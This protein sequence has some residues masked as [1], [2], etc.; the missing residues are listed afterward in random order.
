MRVLFWFVGSLLCSFRLFVSSLLRT[1]TF[2]YRCLFSCA[3]SPQY[4]HVRALQARTLMETVA[5]IRCE[6][7]TH[8]PVFIGG[9]FNALPG[10]IVQTVMCSPTFV[11]RQHVRE[12]PLVSLHLPPPLSLYSAVAVPLMEPLPAPAAVLAAAAATDNTRADARA[13]QAVLQATRE[14][15]VL[16]YVHPSDHAAAAAVHADEYPSFADQYRAEREWALTQRRDASLMPL[17][18]LP[19]PCGRQPPG[20]PAAA[21]TG[22]ALRL[23]LL[24]LGER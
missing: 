5:R 4:D 13:E 15:Y 9:D 11:S 3:C 18:P 21:T 20:A 24:L 1:N 12:N 8:V 14:A 7:G 19:S 22:I 17:T 23:L 2:S 10:N 16:A 6:L